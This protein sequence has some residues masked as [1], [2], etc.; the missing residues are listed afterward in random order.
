MWQWLTGE[1]EAD[2]SCDDDENLDGEENPDC[3]DDGDAADGEDG[4]TCGSKITPTGQ[5]CRYALPGC[6][7]HHHNHH[8]HRNHHHYCIV[9]IIIMIIIIIIIQLQFTSPSLQSQK[10]WQLSLAGGRIGDSFFLFHCFVKSFYNDGECN[11]LA[12]YD[13]D[14]EYGVR[15][16][17]WPREETVGSWTI[18]WRLRFL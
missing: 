3:D 18:L 4:F 11:S 13:D 15:K 14:D 6:Y 12:N 2:N 5:D 17:T 7:R 10:F 8:N 1:N 16:G 9:I